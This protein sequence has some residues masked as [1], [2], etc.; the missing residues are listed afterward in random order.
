[1]STHWRLYVR[2]SLKSVFLKLWWLHI[3]QMSSLLK[4][5]NPCWHRS[6]LFV[7]AAEVD[8]P[9]VVTFLITLPRGGGPPSFQA[10]A[11]LI[12]S[13]NAVRQRRVAT[14]PRIQALTTAASTAGEGSRVTGPAAN[15]AD[16]SVSGRKQGTAGSHSRRTARR[17]TTLLVLTRRRV[18]NSWMRWRAEHRFGSRGASATVRSVP[19]RSVVCYEGAVLCV[20][21]RACWYNS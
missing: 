5:C 15:A 12:H 19:P 1:M 14:A 10:A 3:L 17:K 9:S 16:A 11:R 21:D 4:V 2:Q 20:P 13:S 18:K 8:V 6:T 7:P